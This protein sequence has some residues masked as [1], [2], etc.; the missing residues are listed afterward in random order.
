MFQ[1]VATVKRSGKIY[2]SDGESEPGGVE[3]A[4]VYVYSVRL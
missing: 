4:S 2:F 3:D 1:N